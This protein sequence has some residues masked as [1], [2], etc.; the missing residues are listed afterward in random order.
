MPNLK[1]IRAIINYLKDESEKPDVS[2][3]T[4][5]SLE[6]KFLFNFIIFFI[7]VR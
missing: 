6:G 3:D 2:S 1:I 7:Q 4:K 5:E